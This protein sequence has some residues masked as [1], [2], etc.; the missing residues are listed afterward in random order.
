MQKKITYGGMTTAL[1]VI[2]IAASAYMPTGK[3]ALLFIA[4]F[5]VYILALRTDVK[6]SLISYVAA[7][8]VVFMLTSFANPLITVSFVLCF[9]NYP[10]LKK[11]LDSLKVSVSIIIKFIAYTL[12]FFAVYFAVTK[13][14]D[15]V[16]P[17]GLI[18]LYPAGVIAF[19]FYDFLL[20]NTGKYV[21][22][23]FFK[24]F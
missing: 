1:C 19:A 13:A 22:A 10:V 16:V 5:A 18:I 15:V 17:Y 23:R 14:F 4:S 2:L 3:A 12:Y 20:L 8:A 7:S 21:M 24:S 9:G 11:F 6:T